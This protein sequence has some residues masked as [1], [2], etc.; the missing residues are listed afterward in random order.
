MSFLYQPPPNCP[1][2]YD[3]GTEVVGIDHDRITEILEQ[4]A[5]LLDE[6]RREDEASEV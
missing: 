5:P 1:S 3:F 6:A 4:Y 2:A